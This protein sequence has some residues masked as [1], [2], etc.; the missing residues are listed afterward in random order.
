MC[1]PLGLGLGFDLDA[2]IV[3]CLFRFRNEHRG[4][5]GTVHG[6]LV[7]TVLDEATAWVI[8][9]HAWRFY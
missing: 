7:A 2:R 4:F 6:G 1:N 3:D 5:R 8:G 9:V